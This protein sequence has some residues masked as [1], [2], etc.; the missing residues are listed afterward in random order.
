MWRTIEIPY[1]L[2]VSYPHHGLIPIKRFLHDKWLNNIDNMTNEL[3]LHSPPSPTCFLFLLIT[4]SSRRIAAPYWTGV[5]VCVCVW[6]ERLFELYNIIHSTVTL[7][8][9]SCSP[10]R[11]VKAQS[12]WLSPLCRLSSFSS[13][14][15]GAPAKSWW[16]HKTHNT[17]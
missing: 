14:E 9:S 4:T 10:R 2:F 8:P 11:G 13:T 3:T 1:L 5:C 7:S 6:P 17:I 15:H 16:V 12:L